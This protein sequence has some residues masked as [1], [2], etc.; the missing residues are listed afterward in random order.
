MKKQQNR[1]GLRT[2][3]SY[4]INGSKV[5]LCDKSLADAPNDYAW[6]TD[7]E[8]ARLDA[9]P[10]LNISFIEYQLSYVSELCHPPLAK[11]Q[12]AI[13]TRDGEHIGN[14]AY[15]DISERAGEAEL[16]LMIGNRN[17]WDKGYGIDAVTTLVSHIFS[18]TNLKRIYL[19]TLESNQRAQKCFKRCGFTPYGHRGSGRYS[20]VLMELQRT[21]WQKSKD[22]T[23]KTM[24]NLRGNNRPIAYPEKY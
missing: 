15:Y 3:E 22:K 9:A 11:Y 13:L 6:K 21:K 19:K 14:C 23:D 8:L 1:A 18:K 5:R 24:V 12:F 20:F 4:T 10:L 17:Y 16:G 7:P 2:L